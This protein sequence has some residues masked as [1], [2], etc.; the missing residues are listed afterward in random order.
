MIEF[1][2]IHLKFVSHEMVI[3]TFVH[4]TYTLISIIIHNC[5]WIYYLSSKVLHADKNDKPQFSIRFSSSSSSSS[6]W[7]DFFFTWNQI[8]SWRYLTNMCYAKVATTTTKTLRICTRVSLCDS[9]KREKE[10]NRIK[11]VVFIC[12]ATD[13]MQLNWYQFLLL[14]LYNLR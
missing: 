9:G 13:R 4:Q 8:I 1:E 5:K 3:N 14:F 10:K 11:K 6:F 2:C 12:T 7:F